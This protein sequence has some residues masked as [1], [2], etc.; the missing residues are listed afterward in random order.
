MAGIVL[1]ASKLGSPWTTLDPFLFCVHHL[2]AYPAGNGRLGPAASVSGRVPGMDF[3]S[4]DGWSMYHGEIVPGFPRHP[5][6]GFET[7]T[8]VRRGFI[9]HAD[10][11]GSVARYGPGDVQWL[12]AG[13]GVVHSEMFPLLDQHGPNPLELFQI[14]LNLPG[15]SKPV[16][17]Y[18]SMS[19]A[20]EVPQLTFLD[21]QRGTTEVRVVAGTLE[22][23]SPPASPP[24]SWA[25]R[26]DSDVAIWLVRMT[27]HTTWTLPAARRGSNRAI[28]NYCGDP[29]RIAGEV[30]QGPAAIRLLADAKAMVTSGPVPTEFLLLQGAP[31]GEPIVQHG[32][33]VMNTAAEI[34]EAF[35]EYRRTEFGGWPWPSP[36]PVHGRDRVRFARFSDGRVDAPPSTGQDP[37]RL[38]RL[39]RKG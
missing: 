8:I 23:A 10:S 21:D 39:A 19:W 6:R 32:P 5:H 16:A 14:W 38:T 28:Y 1:G 3:S 22:G 2:D 4:K 13:R 30:V 12:T 7:V 20:G 37:C 35:D 26:P 34:D 24:D 33:F 29:L 11:L 17:P 31:I 15:A 36:G 27:P 9:D 25:S 18:F